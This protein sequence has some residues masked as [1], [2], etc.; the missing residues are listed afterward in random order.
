M[1]SNKSSIDSL[2]DGLLKELE[3]LKSLE[4]ALSQLLQK[5]ETLSEE[6]VLDIF[7]DPEINEISL[8]VRKI[9]TI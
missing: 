1:N 3:A 7:Y 5:Q 4:Q 2:S 9:I 8:M 6:T